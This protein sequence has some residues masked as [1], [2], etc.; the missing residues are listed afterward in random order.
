MVALAL[1]PISRVAAEWPQWGGPN[2]NFAVSIGGVKLD[3][4]PEGPRVLWEAPVGPGSSGVIA[5]DQAAYTLYRD[6][7]SEVV[8]ALD[9]NTGARIWEHKYES[10]IPEGYPSPDQLGPRATPVITGVRVFTVGSLGHVRCLNK[11]TGELIW[12]GN[13]VAELKLVPPKE[14]YSSSPMIYKDRLMFALGSVGA[15][16][17]GG[18]IAY[19]QRAG[20]FLWGHHNYEPVDAALITVPIRG[21]E[22]I[23]VSSSQKI[24]AIDPLNGPVRFEWDIAGSG[25]PAWNSS[26]EVLVVPA[27]GV[28]G[29]EALDFKTEDTAGYRRLW[30]E[31]GP[32]WRKALTTG[33]VA[34]GV[35]D[36]SMPRLC[37]IGLYTGEP[38]FCDESL[39]AAHVLYTGNSLVILGEDGT[40][41]VANVEPTRMSIASRHKFEKTGAWAPPAFDRHQLYLRDAKRVLVLQMN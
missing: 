41:A 21:K 1:A 35:T 36:E 22:H 28:R 24:E 13:P 32:K 37:A 8:V 12:S 29:S 17:A 38:L 6:G 30:S 10:P 18:V 2:R 40:V 19:H 3:W 16:K 25:T 33:N 5:D 11:T 26:R 34:L 15:A 9:V 4:P 7:Q 23:V 14:G 20:N 31:K 27:A 39:P